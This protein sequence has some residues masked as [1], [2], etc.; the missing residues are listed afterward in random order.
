MGVFTSDTGHE[1]VVYCQDK[2]SGLR[3]IIGIYSTALGPAL[4]DVP[5]PV[6]LALTVECRQR[7]VDP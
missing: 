7:L 3:A 6:D 5:A 1:Q 2:Q 4:L